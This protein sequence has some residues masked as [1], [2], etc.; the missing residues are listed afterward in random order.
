MTREIALTFRVPAIILAGMIAAFLL[1]WYGFEVSADVAFTAVTLL[2]SY[3]LVVE[4]VG[5]ALKGQY[6]LDY[7]AI[8]AIVVAFVVHELLVA[9]VIALMIS[10]GRT[11]EAYGV[12]RAQRSLTALVDRIPSDVVIWRN[13]TPDGRLPTADVTVGQQIFVRRGEV[14]PLDGVL[15]SPGGLTD[16]S[17]L[18]G[19]PYEIEKVA[20]DPIRSGTV[21]IGDAI[22][23]EVTRPE[24]QSTYTKIVEMVRHAQDEKAPLVRLADRYSTMFT[25]LTFV[26]CLGAYAYGR[27]WDYVLAVLVI[28]TPCPLILATPIALL[29]GVNSAAHRKIIVKGLA[30]IEAMAR[31]N[32]LI[33]DKTGTITLGRP[34]V[35]EFQVQPHAGDHLD[36]LAAAAAVERGSLHPLAKAIVVHAREHGVPSLP[37]EDVREE[38]GRGI[39][40]SV[41]GRD[42]WLRKQSGGEGMAID[43][44]EGER[45]L[46]TFSFE[47]EI[48]PDSYMSIELLRQMGLEMYLFTGDRRAAAER[49]ASQLGGDVVVR[50]E[51]SPADKREGIAALRARGRTT[52]MVGDGVNDAPALAA[53]DVGLVFSHEEQTAASEAADV[54]FLA[55][56]VGLVREALVIARRSVGIALQSIRWGIGLSVVGML[57]AAVGLIPPIVG[58]FLQEAIDVA[59]ILN[60]LRTARS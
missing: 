52:A 48:K 34:R 20:G 56:D 58:A 53:A 17:S 45:T 40:G 19:E 42:Y 7:I 4:S 31:V 5:L 38:I 44:G 57:L 22:V 18:T 15:V 30:G 12:A 37:A 21:N 32:A 10:S 14:I 35:T 13:G 49:V 16:E 46:G 39:S 29:G 33:F 3:G 8:V 28:A 6:A 36:L 9:A 55:G 11:L 59:V 51:C 27:S 2:G 54:V 43:L 23:V 25:L 1:D 60:A 24:R 50:A 26:I 47:D 41:G